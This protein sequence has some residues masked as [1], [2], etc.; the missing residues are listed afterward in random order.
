MI[1]EGRSGYL[2]GADNGLPR[3]RNFSVASHPLLDERV[4]FNQSR[5]RSLESKEV[6]VLRLR[7]RT[8]LRHNN[9]QAAV[10]LLTPIGALF[11][12]GNA[13]TPT[14][15][16]LSVALLGSD[17]QSETIDYTDEGFICQARENRVIFQIFV[18]DFTRYHEWLP[19]DTL[20]S[21][22]GTVL[23]LLNC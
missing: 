4:Y 8:F 1:F 22:Y 7:S 14:K 21:L 16:T 9:C 19:P 12:P 20:P 5:V 18:A 11:Q 10:F 13:S 23:L 2:K 17:C 6:K 15:T 3:S